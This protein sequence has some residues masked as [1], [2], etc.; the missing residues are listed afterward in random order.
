MN[1]RIISV[2][3]YIDF[4]SSLDTRAF[5]EDGGEIDVRNGGVYIGYFLEDKL[6]GVISADA[7]TGTTVQVHISM[8]KEAYG[9]AKEFMKEALTILFSFHGVLKVVAMI[10]TFN[11]LAIRLARHYGTKEGQITKCFLKNWKLH[12]MVI[13]GLTRTE[14]EVVKCRQ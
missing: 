2:Q 1:T 9:R 5:Q 14:W 6:C 11:K 4:L 12:D 7:M 13:Y 3:E 8:S 10:P